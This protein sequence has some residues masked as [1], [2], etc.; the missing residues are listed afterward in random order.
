MKTDGHNQRY[1][2]SRLQF[3]SSVKSK[4]KRLP[5]SHPSSTTRF[6]TMLK[7]KE[8]RES[9]LAEVRDQKTQK[10]RGPTWRS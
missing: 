2:D 6:C 9:I 10:E 4:F 7:D 5:P 1:Y 8:Y 3:R